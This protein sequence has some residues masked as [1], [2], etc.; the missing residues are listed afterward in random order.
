MCN[1]LGGLVDSAIKV[2]LLLIDCWMWISAAIFF[3]FARILLYL[4][5]GGNLVG[6]DLLLHDKL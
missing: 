2:G 6:G 4:I 3:G 1:V 5:Y